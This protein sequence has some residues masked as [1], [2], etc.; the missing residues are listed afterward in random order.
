MLV[1]IVCANVMFPLFPFHAFFFLLRYSALVV[2]RR[3]GKMD[4][5]SP[6][7]LH[8]NVL[9]NE[10]VLWMC[11]YIHIFYFVVVV[12]VGGVVVSSSFLHRFFFSVGPQYI[13]AEQM[14]TTKFF[15]AAFRCHCF[16]SDV[17]VSVSFWCNYMRNISQQYGVYFYVYA[18]QLIW[19]TRTS[20]RWREQKNEKKKKKFGSL[21][22]YHYQWLWLKYTH[23][24]AHLTTKHTH[25]RKH[26]YTH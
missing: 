8:S 10:N 17:F 3:C 15:D 4:E 18:I 12:V 24:R 23:S 19:E 21:Y 7:N 13:R 16:N 2:W 9:P 14:K 20:Q 6:E 26:T 1:Q 5:K 25:T 11:D 22:T